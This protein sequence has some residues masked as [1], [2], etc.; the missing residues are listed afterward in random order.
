MFQS[1]I[2]SWAGLRSEGGKLCGACGVKKMECS[3]TMTL[4]VTQRGGAGTIS[5]R[6]VTCCP[7]R[8][9]IQCWWA[10]GQKL[11]RATQRTH[12]LGKARGP[13]QRAPKG[14]WPAHLAQNL[15]MAG[16]GSYLLTIKKRTLELSWSHFCKPTLDPP[17]KDRP[18]WKEK[19]NSGLVTCGQALLSAHQSIMTTLAYEAPCPLISCPQASKMLEHWLEIATKKLQ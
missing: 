18:Q 14:P 3:L 13:C 6:T 17:R 4:P 2:L 1:R 15:W 16:S 9:M 8:G 12:W 5:G 19:D 10:A 7:L 11:G